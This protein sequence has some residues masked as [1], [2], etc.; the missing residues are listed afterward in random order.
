MSTIPLAGRHPAPL[1]LAALFALSACASSG[2]GLADDVDTLPDLNE[3]VTGAVAFAA[4]DAMESARA[5][6]GPGLPANARIA[7]ARVLGPTGSESLAS[8]TVAFVETTGGVFVEYDVRGLDPGEHGFH[9]HEGASCD[10]ADIDDD[11]A[12]DPAGA[13]GGHFGPQGSPHG[14][15]S[16]PRTE[17]HAG[18]LGNVTADDARSAFGTLTDEVLSFD[19]PTSI[20]GR[21]MMVHAG[22]DDLTSQ[23]SGAAGDRVACGVIELVRG[24]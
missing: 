17:R 15:P 12:P 23:P 24:E 6:L 18:D 16:D 1:L 10:P 22:R 13:A 8:G 3:G 9:V 20:V 5:A 14:A 2:G 7:V 11:G 19:G 21:A 4:T